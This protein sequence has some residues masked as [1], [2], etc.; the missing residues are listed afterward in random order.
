MKRCKILIIVGG[1]VFG[2]IPARLL[3]MLPKSWQTLDGIDVLAGC[4]VG[5]M[6]A[7]GYAVG[8]PFTRIDTIFREQA[9]KC[10]TKRAAAKINPFAVPKYRNDTMDEV[11]DDIMCNMNM[12][13]VKKVWPKLSLII[14]ALDL[15]YDNY[16]V[17]DNV[18]GK[19]DDVSLAAIA[20]YTSAAPSYFA[21]RDFRGHCLVDGGLIEVAPL[22]TATTC[23]KHNK[24]I[25][26]KD[27]D[28][29]MI[30]TGKDKDEKPLTVKR[31]NGLGL[32]G[33][34]TDV[35]VPYA[36][37]SN[38]MATRYWGETLG[39]GSFV[40]FNPLETNGKLDD[41]SQ[42]PKVVTV[43]EKYRASF[44]AVWEEWLNK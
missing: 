42:I 35:L 19:Y 11:L 44:N 25:P 34:A 1:G 40:Y 8:N 2:C 4:S 21:G 24:G 32:L 41:V 14:P 16:I 33:I 43:T 37:L 27:M 13:D 10:F 5:G 22:L 3:A 26:F 36:T 12:G 23:I 18:R 30:G 7:A 28:V 29:L 38:E 9:N 20:G 39:L 31:Y 17:F 6:L 15:T